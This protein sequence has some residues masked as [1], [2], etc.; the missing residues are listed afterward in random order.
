MSTN[1][2]PQSNALPTANPTPQSR[3]TSAEEPEDIAQESLRV[4]SAYASVE[5]MF[6]WPIFDDSAAAQKVANTI[7]A[8]QSLDTKTDAAKSSARH[9]ATS[10]ANQQHV[11]ASHNLGDLVE[12]FISSVHSRIP[13]LDSAELRRAAAR[14]TELGPAWDCTPCLVV[15]HQHVFE[16]AANEI[17]E[18]QFAITELTCTDF[19][20]HIATSLCSWRDNITFRFYTLTSAR[21]DNLP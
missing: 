7:I 1:R 2:L 13:F 16:W 19:P 6:T 17:L 20:L 5:Q 10:I 14:G 4:P 11:S 21:R 15:S 18:L 3:D 8:S 9:P 12:R